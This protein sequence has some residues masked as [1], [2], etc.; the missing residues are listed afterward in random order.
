MSDRSLKAALRVITEPIEDYGRGWILAAE[1]EK[2]ADSV[3]S[4]RATPADL[5]RLMLGSVILG[6]IIEAILPTESSL[7]F[8]NFPLLV[9]R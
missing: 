8:T 3:V 1:P 7:Q 9:K 2:L 6:S 4:G 5:V